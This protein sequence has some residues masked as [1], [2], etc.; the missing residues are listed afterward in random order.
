MVRRIQGGDLDV[1]GFAALLLEITEVD[2]SCIRH[3]E[4]T[5]F[6]QLAEPSCIGVVKVLA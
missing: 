2:G 5:N 3:V 1:A 6:R 4:D